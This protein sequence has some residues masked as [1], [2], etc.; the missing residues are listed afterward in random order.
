MSLYFTVVFYVSHFAFIAHVL[1]LIS[2][3][4]KFD[5]ISHVTITISHYDSISHNVT[6]YLTV[7]LKG[8]VYLKKKKSIL[9]SFTH[10]PVWISFFCCRRQRK[11]R[12]FEECGTVDVPHWLP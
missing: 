6:L 2:L 8:I 3:Y 12:Y 11:W 9:S 10:P 1:T 7:W 4:P 5:F